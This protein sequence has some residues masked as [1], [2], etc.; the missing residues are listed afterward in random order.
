MH[1]RLEVP[2]AVK[3]IYERRLRP[4]HP[5]RIVRILVR[6]V[7][8]LKQ[9]SIGKLLHRPR[10]VDHSQVI[11]WLQQKTDPQAGNIRNNLYLD[12][13]K[14]AR[15]LEGLL[16]LLN[17]LLRIWLVFVLRYQLEKGRE[18]A[19][20]ICDQRNSADVLPFIGGLRRL[21]RK[22]RPCARGHK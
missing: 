10:K 11:R 4:R 18:I 5:R 1:R 20:W 9:A 7:R 8:Y 12:L 2:I 3:E 17:L 21:P 14:L 19:M 15:L 22:L 13:G 6:K 16:A